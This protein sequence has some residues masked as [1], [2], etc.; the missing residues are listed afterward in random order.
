M[1]E[2]IY[3]PVFIDE[4]GYELRGEAQSRQCAIDSAFAYNEKYH[5]SACVVDK[6]T[7]EVIYD[8]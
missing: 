6:E 5:L 4:D 2:K 7:G 1:N 8:V 3:I